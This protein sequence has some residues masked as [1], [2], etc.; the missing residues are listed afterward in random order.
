MTSSSTSMLPHLYAQGAVHLETIKPPLED[1]ITLLEV[2]PDLVKTLQY[3]IHKYPPPPPGP[4]TKYERIKFFY[5]DKWYRITFKEYSDG[6]IAM[7]SDLPKVSA[8]TINKIEIIPAEPEPAL[9]E[10]PTSPVITAVAYG[11]CA[12]IFGPALLVVLV[13]AALPL[14]FIAPLLG[15]IIGIPLTILFFCGCIA[16]EI[17][18]PTQTPAPRMYRG[19]KRGSRNKTR[20]TLKTRSPWGKHSPWGGGF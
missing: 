10:A 3:L 4:A 11:V 12:A 20:F 19:R 8:A 13:I 17:N 1:E 16:S 2:P 7:S 14:L 15:G 6:S 5:I 18:S 9:M